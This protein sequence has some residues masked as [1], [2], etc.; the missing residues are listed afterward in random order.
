MSRWTE[1]VDDNL[2]LL[3][4]EK[5]VDAGEEGV[6]VDRG[7]LL[8][9][10]QLQIGVVYQDPDRIVAG[11][12]IAE[13]QA[14][15]FARGSQSIYSERAWT[16]F[17]ARKLSQ[18]GREY[19]YFT[20]V[21]DIMLSSGVAYVDVLRAE[22]QERIQ[23]KNIQLTREYL[24]LARLRLEV[25]VA[26]A[27]ELYRWQVTLADNQGSVVDAR[28]LVSQTQNRAQSRAQPALGAADR[29]HRSSRRR[30]GPH[31]GPRTIRSGST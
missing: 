3:V 23:R 13:W 25:G 2:D 17:K 9:Q 6:K 27:S 15:T 24:E 12:Q 16:R 5:F 20:D 10:G 7:P 8:P 26:N 30:C 29:A 4:S 14:T 11:G 19:G 22:A 31:A 21:L 28:A 18:E 1:A